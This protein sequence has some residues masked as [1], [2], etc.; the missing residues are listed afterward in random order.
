MYTSDEA[1]EALLFLVDGLELAVTRASIADVLHCSMDA[2][3]VEQFPVFTRELT[4]PAQVTEF[5][6]GRQNDDNRT[7]SRLA[8]LSRCLLFLDV[9]LKKNI[10]PLGHKEEWRGDLLRAL[11]RFD[12]RFWV[13]IPTLIYSQ[14]NRIFNKVKVHNTWSSST[15]ALPFT[16]LF[17]ALIKAQGTNPLNPMR[18]SF[19]R[20]HFTEKPTGAKPLLAYRLHYCF[21][22]PRSILMMPR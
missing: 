5:Y 12:F 1:P 19:C 16:N 8:N 22:K 10:I 2:I 7:S 18:F 13:D 6:E 11:H 20:P 3:N 17:T 14:M 21:P 4:I 15:Q 9:V